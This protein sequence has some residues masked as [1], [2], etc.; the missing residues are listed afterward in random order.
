M[1]PL[2]KKRAARETFRQ[3]TKSNPEYMPLD[4]LRD[5]ADRHGVELAWIKG[6][7]ELYEDLKKAGV[8]TCG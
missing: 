7:V 1:S 3:L 6:R 5:Y 4:D 2:E 8:M